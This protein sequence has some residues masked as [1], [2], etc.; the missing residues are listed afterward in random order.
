MVKVFIITQ[1]EPF[2]IP[3]MIK[4]L[5]S[6]SGIHYTIIGYTVLPPH[7]K[8]KNIRNW[9]F[10]RLKIYNMFEEILILI[11]YSFCTII[12]KIFRKR[13]P[14]NAR[15]IFK[16]NG[17]EEIHS[18]NI[19]SQ[20]YIKKLRAL[21]IDIIISISSPQLFEKELLN[22]PRYGCINAHG[23]L[24]PRHRGVFGSWWA[25]FKKDEYTGATIHTMELKLDSGK[26]LWQEAFKIGSDSQ[27]SI[28]YKTK[29]MMAKGLIKVI[30]DV[31]NGFSN[32]LPE[33]YKSSYHRAPSKQMGKM[34]HKMGL[35]VIRLK[36]IKYIIK[37]RFKY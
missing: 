33:K 9:I 12:N 13:S 19:N 30:L 3:K 15:A 32:N 2:F 31:N 23:T 1:N 24:L 29:K 5:I 8:S 7:R 35:R 16:R 20:E 25:L 37:S 10:E 27:Y 28:A 18:S 36:D 26:I 14:Y 22:V 34:F 11:L 6:E 21:S 17:I 4:H